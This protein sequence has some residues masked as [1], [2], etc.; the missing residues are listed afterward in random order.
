[1]GPPMERHCSST[2]KH[3]DNSQ[4][5]LDLYDY[6]S[7][8]RYA[9][10]IHKEVPFYANIQR[11]VCDIAGDFCCRGENLYDIG[12]AT[13]ATLAKLSQCLTPEVNFIGL[14]HSNAMLRAASRNLK[15]STLRR[16]IRLIKIDHNGDFSVNDA[17]I[18][19]A[20]LTFQRNWANRHHYFMS[21]IYNGL[22][23]QGCFI[24]F[25]RFLALHDNTDGQLSYRY[26]LDASD[27]LAVHSSLCSTTI[28]PIPYE[29]DEYVELLKKTGFTYIERFFKYFD[30]SGFLILK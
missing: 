25:D 11:I 14:D 17:T 27:N 23:M 22:K 18:V 9:E 12:C 8:R 20:M 4:A 1:M 6:Q 16:T 3:S 30:Y 2:S 7:S 28:N 10:T 29:P 13:G 15:P 19:V 21:Q 5:V 26:K 24:L